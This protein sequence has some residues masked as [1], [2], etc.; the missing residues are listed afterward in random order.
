MGKSLGKKIKAFRA[1]CKTRYA[2]GILNAVAFERNGRKL[3]ESELGLQPAKR[4]SL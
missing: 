4:A 3:S 1:R 2:P